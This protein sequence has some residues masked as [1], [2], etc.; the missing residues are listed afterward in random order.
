MSVGVVSDTDTDM[1][2]TRTRLIR[3]VSV[4][5]S[6]ILYKK[7]KKLNNISKIHINIL[8]KKVALETYCTPI[9]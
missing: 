1:C 3:G 7:E 2:S 9:Y 4:L 8:I 5:H 6:F